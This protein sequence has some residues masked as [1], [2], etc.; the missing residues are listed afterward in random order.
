[1]KKLLV[2]ILVLAVFSGCAPVPADIVV[3]S[4]VAGSVVSSPL[5]ISG[6]AKGGWFFEGSFPVYLLDANGEELAASYVTAQS[7]WMTADF[8]DFTGSLEFSPTTESGTLLFKNDNPSGLAENEVSFELPVK[9]E[10]DE[11]A[12][13]EIYIRTNIGDLNPTAPVLGGSW[14]VV[15]LNFLEDGVVEVLAEDGHIQSEF[16]VEYVIEDGEVRVL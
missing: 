7:N 12:L 2:G 8:V 14:Y 13:V 16:T 5:A 9:F 11:R 1:M 15:G 4:P 10:V 3:E 6:E